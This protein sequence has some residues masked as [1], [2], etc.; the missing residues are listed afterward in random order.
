VAQVVVA[1][2][3]QICAGRVGIELR[4]RDPAQ[5]VQLRRVPPAHRRTQLRGCDHAARRPVIVFVFGRD[6]AV[7]RI[8]RL[9]Q[10]AEIIVIEGSRL[11][12]GIG[13][14][15]HQARIAAPGHRARERKRLSDGS[16]KRITAIT[17]AEACAVA[18][19]VGGGVDAAG[20]EIGEGAAEGGRP[21]DVFGERGEIAARAGYRDV[22]RGVAGG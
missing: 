10:P 2:R 20:I 4:L 3:G 22:L 14:G 18:R 1:G 15:T 21:G 11:A 13:N 8:A 17:V 7:V 16:G 6:L 9:R 19:K 5:A 12:V